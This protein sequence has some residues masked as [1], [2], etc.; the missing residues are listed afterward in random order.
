MHVLTHCNYLDGYDLAG[1]AVGA[2]ERENLLP[3]ISDIKANSTYYWT[4][5]I[6]N[7]FQWIFNSNSW[8]L[9]EVFK[10]LANN[11]NI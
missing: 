10:W 7:S 2:I 3:H 1:F 4:S 6:R 9:S 5:I 8:E 11:G